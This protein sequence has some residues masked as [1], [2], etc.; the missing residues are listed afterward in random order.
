[1]DDVIHIYEKKHKIYYYAKVIS[2]INNRSVN[3]NIY[4]DELLEKPIDVNVNNKKEMKFFLKVDNIPSY[5]HLLKDGSC[6]YV[7]RELHQ[8]GYDD[9]TDIETYPFTNGNL[10]VNKNIVFFLRRQNP[11]GETDLRSK[12]YPYD[13]VNNTISFTKENKYY[14]EENMQC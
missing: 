3:I 11:N 6:R 5:S 1:V 2:V 7:Y 12:T 13:I 9:N 4:E 14:H 8:N 10:Y